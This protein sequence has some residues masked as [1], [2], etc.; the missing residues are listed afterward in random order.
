MCD[1][2]GKSEKPAVKHVI[3]CYGAATV[4]IILQEMKKLSAPSSSGGLEQAPFLF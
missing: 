2:D 4:F 1:R 3:L